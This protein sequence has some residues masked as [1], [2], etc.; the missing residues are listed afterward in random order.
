[1]IQLKKYD[2]FWNLIKR[3]VYNMIKI[4]FYLINIEFYIQIIEILL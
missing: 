3:Y 4:E 2:F 1:M